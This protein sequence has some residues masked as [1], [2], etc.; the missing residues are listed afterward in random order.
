MKFAYSINDTAFRFHRSIALCPWPFVIAY[1][2]DVPV[3]LQEIKYLY[4][5][6]LYTIC[7]T[8][9]LT[10]LYPTLYFYITE[11]IKSVQIIIA[12]ARTASTF[13]LRGGKKREKDLVIC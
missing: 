2:L 9:D 11:Q 1:F 12:N 6:N 3:E 4:I 5:Y 10:P 8:S 13:K 7:K